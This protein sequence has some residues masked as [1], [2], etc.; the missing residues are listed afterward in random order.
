MNEAKRGSRPVLPAP[1]PSQTDKEYLEWMR[2]AARADM[3]TATG[4]ELECLEYLE[5][6]TTNEIRTIIKLKKQG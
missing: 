3:A 5:F 6:Y 4:L 2:G 1:D